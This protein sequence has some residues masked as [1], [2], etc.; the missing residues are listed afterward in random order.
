[1]VKDETQAQTERLLSL[2]ALAQYRS[3][4]RIYAA[5][6]IADDLSLASTVRAWLP[7]EIG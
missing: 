5:K 2:N 7:P 6:L 3:C 1:M 4:S